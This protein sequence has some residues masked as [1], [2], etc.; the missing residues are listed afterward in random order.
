MLTRKNNKALFWI[1]T[2]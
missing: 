1:W 2:K